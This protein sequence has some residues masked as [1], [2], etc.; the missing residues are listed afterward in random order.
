MSHIGSV[1]LE[2]SEEE[3]IGR[4]N[5]NVELP[6]SWSI[7]GE[8]AGVEG[9]ESINVPKLRADVG[10]DI[11]AGLMGLEMM[12]GWGDLG[13]EKRWGRS[14]DVTDGGLGI[15]WAESDLLLATGVAGTVRAAIMTRVLAAIQA[16]CNAPR[17]DR[18]KF[19]YKYATTGNM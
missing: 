2:G 7:R 1:G 16:Q 13:P 10:G 11:G 19:L 8:C 9:S 3:D 5:T 17:D 15:P 4:S 6:Q 18:L 14:G 12:N